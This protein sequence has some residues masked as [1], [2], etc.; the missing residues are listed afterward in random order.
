MLIGEYSIT[1]GEARVFDITGGDLIRG[2]A[3]NNM[4][5]MVPYGGFD[6]ITAEATP[7]E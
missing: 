2:F 6:T 1:S 3:W 5:D 4:K 7:A